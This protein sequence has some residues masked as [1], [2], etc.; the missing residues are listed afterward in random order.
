MTPKISIPYL[1]QS[2]NGPYHLA[3][4]CRPQPHKHIY[5]C[6]NMKATT[7]VQVSLFSQLNVCTYHVCRMSYQNKNVTSAV[8]ENT[9]GKTQSSLNEGHGTWEVRYRK[10]NNSRIGPVVPKILLC[11]KTR[12][13]L[14]GPINDICLICLRSK[15]P[16]Y[17]QY[18][19]L[20]GPQILIQQEVTRTIKHAEIYTTVSMRRM[21]LF[22]D[23][24]N[25]IQNYKWSVYRTPE[26]FAWVD[27]HRIP[28]IP[29]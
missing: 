12:K 22:A 7:C 14:S 6:W 2:D 20:N 17:W 1:L 3:T 9:T 26:T 27:V 21:R 28:H 13:G 8:V 25:K 24:L 11:R 23:H 16:F 5:L 15:K 18:L 19:K 4:E 10:A 29:V